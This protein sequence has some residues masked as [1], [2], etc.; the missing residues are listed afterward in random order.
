[1][2]GDSV[3]N[4]IY[5]HKLVYSA[6]KYNLFWYIYELSPNNWYI[7]YNNVQYPLN[8]K[9]KDVVYNLIDTIYNSTKYTYSPTTN[10]KI[11]ING[12]TFKTLLRSG[13][14]FNNGIWTY[15]PKYIKIPIECKKLQAKN[16]ELRKR[17]SKY[18][19][20]RVP[21]F[22]YV[23]EV[24]P[25]YPINRLRLENPIL[26][27]QL[28][29]YEN[30]DSYHKGL[31]WNRDT[32]HAKLVLLKKQLGIG[33]NEQ[34][35]LE[36]VAGIIDFRQLR[37]EVVNYKKYTNGTYVE[38]Y[39]DSEDEDKRPEDYTQEEIM[40]FKNAMKE[41]DKLMGLSSESSDDSI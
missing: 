16:D 24:Y 1:M 41:A 28:S 33:N 23:K 36:D 3:S 39:S 25:D 6:S 9:N 21:W 34:I 26:S 10:Q 35:Y 11:M 40:E 38:S 37:E 17:I 22:G 29:E 4:D 14:T 12:P 30:P 13:Y 15:N 5:S 8:S 27:E 20:I 19:F 32:E 18:A 2:L 7:P 31:Y